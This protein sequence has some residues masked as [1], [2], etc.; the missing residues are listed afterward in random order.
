MEVQF[1]SSIRYGRPLPDRTFLN[2]N[3]FWNISLTQ[4]SYS[5]KKVFIPIL[6]KLAFQNNIYWHKTRNIFFILSTYLFS[7]E[8]A[9]WEYLSCKKQLQWWLLLINC[10]NIREITLALSITIDF[11]ALRLTAIQ[12]WL[13]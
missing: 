9:Q 7:T 2:I 3:Y 6:E 5:N 8:H 11:I 10:K 1:N 4:C 13:H 12:F